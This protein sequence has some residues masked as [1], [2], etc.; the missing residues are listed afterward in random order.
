[1][2][3]GLRIFSVSGKTIAWFSAMAQVKVV[4]KLHRSGKEKVCAE[5]EAG[6]RVCKV[7]N[8]LNPGGA[9]EKRL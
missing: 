9:I 1:M 4:Q 6:R 8:C 2:T 5:R 3:K 7:T